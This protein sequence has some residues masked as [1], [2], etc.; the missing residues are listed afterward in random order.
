VRGPGSECGR[1]PT[2]MTGM[3]GTLAALFYLHSR[4]RDQDRAKRMQ[5]WREQVRSYFPRCIMLAHDGPPNHRARSAKTFCRC[6]RQ[7]GQPS[8]SR[9]GCRATGA[10][11]TGLDPRIVRSQCCR[12]VGAQVGFETRFQTTTE[13]VRRRDLCRESRSASRARCRC[14]G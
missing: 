2:I 9:T 10:V 14:P 11:V 5:Y 7:R 13:T 6:A 3:V 4:T 12:L 8:T 1:C